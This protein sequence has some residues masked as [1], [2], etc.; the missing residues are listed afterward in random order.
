[1][2]VPEFFNTIEQTGLSRWIRYSSSMFGFY[3][4]LLCHTIGLSLLV[5]GNAVVDLRILGVARGLPLKPMKDLFKFMFVGLAINITTGLLLLTGYPT[6][7]LTD[8]DF[9]I[10]I[11]FVT[12]GATTMFLMYKRV[13]KDPS[14][15]ESDMIRRGKTLAKLSIVFWVFAV[16][17]GRMLSETYIYITYGH[18]YA[19]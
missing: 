3:F 19:R 16:W 7:A 18:K 10:K 17:A 9:Y 6:K 1:L 15:S 8:F 4:I 13:F 12:L 2:A 14:L 5:G 11:S